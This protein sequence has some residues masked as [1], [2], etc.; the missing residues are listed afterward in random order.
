MSR[1]FQQVATKGIKSFDILHARKQFFIKGHPR[2]VVG[3]MQ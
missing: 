2:E 1:K 3:S